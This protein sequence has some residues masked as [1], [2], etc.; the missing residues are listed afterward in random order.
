[1]AA[2]EKFYVAAN[3]ASTITTA[4][5]TADIDTFFFCNFLRKR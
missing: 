3:N 1:M 2:G 5:N 4:G